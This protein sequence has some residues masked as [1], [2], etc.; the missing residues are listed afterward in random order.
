MSRSL[1][2]V[3]EFVWIINVLDKPFLTS[4]FLVCVYFL[5]P[6]CCKDFSWLIEI[7]LPSNLPISL[8]GTIM[9]GADLDSAPGFPVAWLS[10]PALPARTCPLVSGFWSLKRMWAFTTSWPDL[11][12]IPLPESAA[13]LAKPW[14]VVK[15]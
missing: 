7:F 2:T 14:M 5:P 8:G 1:F 9:P 11:G 3:I 12:R 10:S 15:G 6:G 4:Y 13:H